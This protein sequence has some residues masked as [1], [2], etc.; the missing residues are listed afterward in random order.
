MVENIFLLVFCRS[1]TEKPLLRHF[2]K[3]YGSLKSRICQDNG[4][5][6]DVAEAGGMVFS[7]NKNINPPIKK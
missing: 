4:N 1:Y 7:S 2:M 5:K 6:I 3:H